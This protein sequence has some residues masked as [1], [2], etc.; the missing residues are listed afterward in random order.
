MKNVLFA[1]LGITLATIPNAC[2]SPDKQVKN[3]KND[4]T[5]FSFE[6]LTPPVTAHIDESEIFASVPR[7]T[8]LSSL[9]A[10]YTTNGAM[11]TVGDTVQRSGI[12][13]NDFTA[14]LT[15]T[16]TADDGSCR[17]YLVTIS[18]TADKGERILGYDI[19]NLTESG[20]F[21]D[22]INKA[23]TLG[24]KFISL[25]LHWNAIETSPGVFTDPG[26]AMS[27]LNKAASSNGLKMALI[28]SPIDIPGRVTPA[29]LDAAAFNE[30]AMI[31]RF[32]NCLDFILTKIN[33]DIL[34]SLSI[35]NEIDAYDWKGNG[36]SPADYAAFLYQME[37]H[38]DYYSIKTAFTGTHSGLIS[39]ALRD[40]GTWKS[41]AAVV[42]AIH[43]TYYPMDEEFQAASPDSI[44]E[45]LRI[46]TEEFDGVNS[47]EGTQIPLILQEVGYHT[48]PH[49]SGSPEKQAYFF[50]HFFLAWDKYRNMIPQ[51]SIL[52]MCDTSLASAETTAASYN[53]PGNKEFIE[54][55]RTLGLRT[56][57]G[58]GTDKPAITL[59]EDELLK[60]SW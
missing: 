59:I 46:L 39:G 16:V 28:I 57:D 8:D 15:Y 30:A 48:S 34:T 6:S 44:Y 52:R 47:A 60:R 9:S 3:N 49:C 58:I 5:S 7:N 26:G 33:P 25:H 43:V 13:V 50:Y 38:L 12:T 1:V 14:P 29:D 42:D 37:S 41:M 35:G 56:F 20:T 40:S 36:D 18:E 31:D 11:V 27:A 21:D 54:F 55:T 2:T 23:L 17:S 51:A 53:I 45:D 19:L 32:K 10:T 24:L 22:N 4:I